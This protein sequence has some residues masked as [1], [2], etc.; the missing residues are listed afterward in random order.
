MVFVSE[1]LVFGKEMQMFTQH[2][3]ISSRFFGVAAL[4]A[5]TLVLP[6]CGD[7]SAAEPITIETNLPSDG[8]GEAGVPYSFTFVYNADAPVP[9]HATMGSELR[10]SQGE[11]V[12]AKQALD[13]GDD[14]TFTWTFG[15]GSQPGTIDTPLDGHL[16]QHTVDH[17]YA[18]DGRYG[19]VATVH[20]EDNVLLATIDFIVTIGEIEEEE[21]EMDACDVWQAGNS[22][23]YGVTITNWDISD[24]PAN[25]V[26]DVRF[27]AFSIPDKIVVE[28]P[29]RTKVLD[30]GWRGSASYDGDLLYPGGVTSPGSLEILDVFTKNGPNKFK[31]TVIGPDTSTA[32][33][34]KVRCR[35]L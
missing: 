2:K 35:I 25:A 26:F 15:D 16:A 10:H 18:V 17:T 27:D 22:G 13:H 33:D 1:T 30:T 12:T 34:Y 9:A 20:D 4:A 8:H 6:A 32:W 5:L 29:F 3:Q 11:V 24:I 19:L 14:V 7:D 28:Y 21:D 31:V 23:G